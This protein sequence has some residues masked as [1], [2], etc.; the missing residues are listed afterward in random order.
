MR[1]HSAAS[2]RHSSGENQNENGVITDV[3]KGLYKER[4]ISQP[5]N[6]NPIN[7]HQPT[8]TTYIN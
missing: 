6:P 4:L 1:S 8:T 2:A 3:A 7:N 5:V